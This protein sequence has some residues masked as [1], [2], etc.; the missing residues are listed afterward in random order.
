MKKV[1][2]EKEMKTGSIRERKEEREGRNG[3]LKEGKKEEKKME[4]DRERERGRNR[5]RKREKENKPVE[6]QRCANNNK[7]TTRT[8]C[9]SLQKYKINFFLI[10]N[11]KPS[12]KV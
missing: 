3:E 4:V 5:G 8:A 6:A 11:N 12:I 9:I 2:S 1:K 7:A 10:V